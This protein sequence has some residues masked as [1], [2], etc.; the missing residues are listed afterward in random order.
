MTIKNNVLTVSALAYGAELSSVQLFNKEL[1]Y[2]ANQSWKYHDHVIFP[3][4]G[5]GAHAF[6]INGNSHSL[7]QHGFARE[8]DFL[9]KQIG[10]ETMEYSLENN[11]H[12]ALNYPYAFSFKAI[13]AIEEDVLIR[14]YE[15]TNKS[16]EAM[17]YQVGDHPAYL[18]DFEK[19]TLTFP[20]EPV[21][22]YPCPDGFLTDKKTPF[23]KTGTFRLEKSLFA[24]DD[25]IIID[26]PRHPIILDT[27]RGIRIEF[28]FNSPFIAIWSPRNEDGFVCIEPWWGLGPSH[29]TP[30]ELKERSHYIKNAPGETKT[31]ESRTRFT[32][33]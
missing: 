12:T 29:S 26:N 22:Q 1:L 5:R 18:V 9:E 14:R 23:A 4:I 31:F 16:G 32:L 10:E 17:Y 6:S 15:V 11:G 3:I 24:E 25:T 20:D 27:G 7:P 21:A 30:L 2:Q 8:S 13:Y 19:A 28:F 33:I